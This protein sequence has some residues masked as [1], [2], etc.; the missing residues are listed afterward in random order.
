MSD[1]DLR[2][3]KMEKLP[4]EYTKKKFKDERKFIHKPEDKENFDKIRYDKRIIELSKKYNLDNK[5]LSLGM[6]DDE[7][8]IM[9]LDR[10]D[11]SILRSTIDIKDK[12]IEQ[13]IEQIL[14]DY[15]K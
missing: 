6:V 1:L 10:I 12:T 7:F 3:F 5:S 8:T 4:D 9:I 14:N 13:T 15:K 11:R 2:N